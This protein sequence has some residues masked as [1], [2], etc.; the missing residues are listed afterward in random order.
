MVAEHVRAR[1]QRESVVCT[2]AAC[3]EPNVGETALTWGYHSEDALKTVDRAW[4][5]DEASSSSGWF[6][7]LFSGLLISQPVPRAQSVT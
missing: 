7:S 2:L 5:S 3:D 1:E 6:E 4:E